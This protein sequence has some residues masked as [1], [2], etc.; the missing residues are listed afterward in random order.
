MGNKR[1]AHFTR[2]E[3]NE[4]FVAPYDDMEYNLKEF[5]MASPYAYYRSGVW[6]EYKKV[7]METAI[8]SC[9]KTS[10][11]ADIFIE[12]DE[13]WELGKVD[14]KCDIYFSCPCQSDMW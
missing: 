11:G 3:E 6:N 2:V 10:W 5:L 1:I 12:Y 13:N 8:E 4:V 14:G 7:P 9:K